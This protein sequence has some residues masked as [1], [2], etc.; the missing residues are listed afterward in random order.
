MK[1]LVLSHDDVTDLLSVAECI[2]LMRDTLTALSSGAG[3]QPLRTVVAPPGQPGFLGLMPGFVSASKPVLGVKLLGIFGANPA[4]GKDTHQGAVVLLDPQTGEMRAVVNASAITAVRT[5][6]VSAVA[7]DVLATACASVLTIIGTG[8]TAQWHA[9]AL[10][11]V[12]PLASIRLVGRATARGLAVAAALG[13]ELPVPIT[14]T[15][16]TAAAL[17]GADLVVTATTSPEPVIDRAWLAPGVHI[18]AVGACRPAERELD[19]ATV[20]EAAFF[21]DRRES[22]LRESGDLLLSGLGCDHIRGEVGEVCAGTVGGR[23]AAEQI[24]VF[25]SLGLAVEDL[26][27]A[28]HVVEAAART[29]HGTWVDF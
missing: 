20:A 7:T 3:H 23:A 11:H 10:I 13:A 16:D 22:A 21:V 19:S 5:A 17:D 12:R 28:A 2:P 8:V 27:A 24:T 18:N 25:E 29:G 14:F 1:V 6:A 9:R 26:A 15:T 4:L